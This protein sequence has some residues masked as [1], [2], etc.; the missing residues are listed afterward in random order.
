MAEDSVAPMR[1]EFPRW[2]SAVDISENRV[3]LAMRWQGVASL[4]AE[5]DEV[6]VEAMLALLLRTK[7]RPTPEARASL[8][9]H[10]KAAD[11]LF[12][13]GDNDREME[14]LAGAALVTVLGSDTKLAARTALSLSVALF[15]GARTTEFPLDLV[16]LSEGSIARIS[17]SRRARPQL[18][19]LPAVPRMGLNNDHTEKLKPGPTAENVTAAMNYLA[20]Q[21]HT[22]L[23][24]V[25]ARVNS[26][27]ADANQ[28]AAIQ[29]EELQLLW[30]L[31]GGR[32]KTMDKPFAELPVD[33]QPIIL[34][35]E[36][37]DATQFLPGPVS[38][39]PILSRAGLKERKRIT[40][41]AAI[42][43]CD[44]V[45]LEKLIAGVTPSSVTQPFHFGIQRKL[46]TGDENSW[47]AGWAAVT[48][49]D[50]EFA[51]PG[52]QLGNLFYRE[53]LSVEFGS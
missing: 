1:D 22:N 46:E 25:V 15:A 30:W 14:I 50:A 36:L 38:I 40:V 21:A 28:F 27:L 4:A 5:A 42:N 7:T 53:R 3:R 12:D 52:I 11:E 16:A 39:K 29:D 19:T 34:A 23:R 9:A 31:F 13:V 45:F 47:I 49:I 10:F 48:G 18:A 37:A 32:S 44:R 20:N 51:L 35:S 8:R 24:D 33:G 41:T 17:N 6:L 26:A 2:Y 43:A